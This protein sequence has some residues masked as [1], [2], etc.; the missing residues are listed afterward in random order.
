VDGISFSSIDADECLWLERG[1]EEQEVWEVVREMNGDKAS[2]PDGFSMAFFQ[3]CWGVLKK[4]IMAIFSEFYN[5]CQFERS[6]KA[7]FVS[8]IPKK[9]DVMEVK[10]FRPISFVGGVYK[11]ISKVL[12][13][14]LKSVLWK[15]IS[16]SQNAFGGGRQILDSVLIANECLDSQ[17]QSGE[18]GLLC[19]L[20]LEKA[21]DH[22]NWDFLLYM[23]QR[24]GFGERW[25]EWIKFCVSIVKFSILVN[26]VPFGFFQS[27][28]GI[29]Q[30]DHLS[31]L[32]FVVVMEALSR[33][34]N[35][36]MLQGLLSGFSVGFM[37]NESLVVNHL[38]F[39]DDILIFC[40]AQAE[41][42]RN[43]R[44]TFLCF[45]A[46]SGLRINLGKSELVPIGG[47]ED[48]ESL[49]Y[50]L[51]CRI[52]SL[53]MTYLG[54]P[55]GASFK[56]ISIWNGVIEKVE[57]RLASWKKLY[58]SK[59]DRVTL[60]Y[61]TLS[62]ITTYYLS[63]FPIPVSVAKKLERLQREFLWSGF[64]DETK[65]HLVNWHR[66]CTPVKAGGLGVRNVINFNQALLGKW[67]WRFSQERDALWRSV[68]EVKYGS[69]RGGWCSLPVTGPYSVSV[70]KFIRRG[71]DNVAKYL[72]FE[73]G[74]G[75][76]IRF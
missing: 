34:L 55:L 21:Y 74:D 48:V 63:L 56:S 68:I 49:A 30:G 10:D 70:W 4:D 69:V 16:S 53:P 24:C 38:L 46:V 33:M 27:S 25:R 72:R 61:S 5:S 26:G 75:S 40:G 45:E 76:H 51:G 7:T 44:C 11:I 47:V 8:L 1:F 43:L 54:M 37:G 41:H 9:A 13:N 31:P 36:S 52:G 50:I 35:A 3:K 17:R 29:R 60:I 12:A 18:A 28:R 23:L 73:V 57:R 19:K 65:F 2:G 6:L 39:A 62:S 22:V 20:D 32:L 59:D 14:R 42:V 15:I 66:V 67:I 58:L 71:W 64:G